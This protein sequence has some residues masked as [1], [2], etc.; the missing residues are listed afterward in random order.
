MNR[1]IL[2][3]LEQ[4]KALLEKEQY[5][6]A[7]RLADV[8]ALEHPQSPGLLDLRV[9][10]RIELRDVP[11]KASPERSTVFNNLGLYYWE[12]GDTETAT[13]YFSDAVKANSTSRDAVNNLNAA[14]KIRGLPTVQ[15]TSM[16]VEIERA[17]PAETSMSPAPETGV[18]SAARTAGS[19]S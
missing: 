18:L 10:L 19:A 9:N 11:F 8:L 13:R 1:D 14:F 3:K 4:L 7:L 15:A 17:Q 16:Q 5:D 2:G 6:A 12:A